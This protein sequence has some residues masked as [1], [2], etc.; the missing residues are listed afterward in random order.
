MDM[1]TSQYHH[2]YF[3]GRFPASETELTGIAASDVCSI[4]REPADWSYCIL[5][6][7]GPVLFL[8]TNQ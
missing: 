6:F 5:A 8:S 1:R 4:E 2:L 3:I 7:T